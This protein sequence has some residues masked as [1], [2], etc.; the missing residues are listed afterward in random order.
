M[1]A[2]Q[3][4][5]HF[6]IYVSPHL[7]IQPAKAFNLMG[8]NRGAGPARNLRPISIP[9]EVAAIVW[10]AR[11]TIYGEKLV[12][13]D[14]ENACH[15]PESFGGRAVAKD[16]SVVEHDGADAPWGGDT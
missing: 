10:I 9:R 4:F 14:P 7:H 8:M 3:P 12:F 15:F 13:V 16:F 1:D 6:L 5:R 11:G 2:R